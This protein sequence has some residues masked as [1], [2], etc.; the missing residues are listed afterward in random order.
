MSPIK[1]VTTS[2][3]IGK[4]QPTPES[5]YLILASAF[6]K[7][8]SRSC[9]FKSNSSRYLNS[10]L[11]E[12]TSLYSSIKDKIV[13]DSFQQRQEFQQIIQEFSSIHCNSKGYDNSTRLFALTVFFTTTFLPFYQQDLSNQ[14]LNR[15]LSKVES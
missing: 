8:T 3:H 1:V 4:G 14:I 12:I 15:Q 10:F 6:L 9:L 13:I 5:E 11:S 2:M 7:R